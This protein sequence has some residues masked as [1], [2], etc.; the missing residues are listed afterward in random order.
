MGGVGVAEQAGREQLELQKLVAELAL[1][2]DTAYDTHAGE[3]RRG[4]GER[5]ACESMERVSE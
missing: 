5:N 2:A 3:R 1:V 4:R